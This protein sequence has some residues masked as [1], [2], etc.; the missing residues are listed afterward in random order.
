M[1]AIHTLL[2]IQLFIPVENVVGVVRVRD[3]VLG[4][5]EEPV[6][7]SIVLVGAGGM[8]TKSN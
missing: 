2:G 5:V 3:C 4:S 6:W 8:E 7:G 1:A